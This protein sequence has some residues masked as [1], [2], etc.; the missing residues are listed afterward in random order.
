MQPK[1]AMVDGYSDKDV[2]DGVNKDLHVWEAN[3]RIPTQRP[4]TTKA[5]THAISEPRKFEGVRLTLSG[6]R[7][8]VYG[9]I[10]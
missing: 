7:F 10:L 2:G 1:V 8:G 6:L 5:R 4:K 3:R 9:S